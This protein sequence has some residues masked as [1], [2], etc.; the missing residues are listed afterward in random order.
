M[1]YQEITID[2]RELEAP[3]PLE[4]V[5]SNLSNINETNYI[6][7]IH[8]IEPMMLYTVLQNN[9]YKYITLYKGIDVI[10]F[11]YTNDKI[12]EYIECLQD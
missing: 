6:K 7:M 3:E 4:R 11:I 12:K 1:I 10:I 2:C 8:R 9:G 5:T